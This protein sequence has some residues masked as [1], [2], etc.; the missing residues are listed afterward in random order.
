M[1]DV[2]RI[3]GNS[4]NNERF[5]VREMMLGLEGEFTY[6][7]CAECAC[8]HLAEPPKNLDDYNL[9]RH[10]PLEERTRIRDNPLRAFK[11]RRRA[12][13]YLKGRDGLGWLLAKRER[14]RRFEWFRQAGIDFSSRILDVGCGAGDLL[15]RM[16]RE[17]FTDLNGI[18]WHLD[19]D[20]RYDNA[21]VVEHKHLYD[22][23]GAYDFI[24]LHHSFEHLSDP[25]AAMGKLHDLC[26]PGGVVLLRMPIA[27][28]FGW[29]SYKT[30]WI[31]LNAPRHCFVYS[32][33]G[34]NMLAHK[35]GF[36]VDDIIFDS[37]ESLFY[38][39][40]QYRYG[41]PALHERS[42]QVN[43]AASIFNDCLIEDFRSRAAELNQ[44][45]DGDQAC[46]Y[47]RRP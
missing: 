40:E 4:A 19:K 41:I 38:G 7:R 14:P 29:R 45:S 13:Y 46:V 25:E 33:K 20:I 23:D 32:R 30:D 8:I 17:G 21:L 15:L 26:A 36:S 5:Q 35:A 22:I 34:I 47:L 24:M 3:C 9:N 44:E 39:S 31:R 42:W 18:D 12:N 2:C 28:T 10:R 11:K 6:I 16:H 37:D 1:S 43:P 27:D